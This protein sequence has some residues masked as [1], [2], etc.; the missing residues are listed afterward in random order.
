M[1]FDIE[2]AALALGDDFVFLDDGVLL[3]GADVA[4][5][6]TS[7]ARQALLG[8]DN[9]MARLLPWGARPDRPTGGA[10]GGG[11]AAIPRRTTPKGAI[12]PKFTDSQLVIQPTKGDG[13]VRPPERLRPPLDNSRRPGAPFPRAYTARKRT[14]QVLITP[15]PPCPQP[16]PWR[17]ARGSTSYNTASGDSQEGQV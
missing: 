11:C 4:F 3:T 14:G 12:I 1:A 17:P 16:G 9:A 6:W 15:G 10:C 7:G 8:P 5:H 13:A 2:G